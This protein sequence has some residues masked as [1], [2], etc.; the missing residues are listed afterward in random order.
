MAQDTPV[1][2]MALDLAEIKG[3]F[4]DIYATL[5]DWEAGILPQLLRLVESLPDAPSRDKLLHAFETHS[6]VVE[7]ETPTMT[8][9]KVLEETYVRMAAD[10]GVACKQEDKVAFG[11]SIGDWPAFPDTVEAMKILA[12]H[13]KLY[14]LS[15]VDNASFE[16][17]R[18]GP[19]KSGH[20]DGIYTAEM[21]GS[22]KPNPNNYLYVAQRMK[23]DFGMKDSEILP[24]AQSLD[25]DHVTTKTLGFRPGVYITR[26]GSSMGGNK[27]QME[28]DGIIKLGATYA[29]LGELAEAVEK[30]F[31]AKA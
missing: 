23:D 22:Y 10:F 29:T 27:E 2:D 1:A 12:K 31:A 21:I 24:V 9:N 26:S 5:I 8:Y 30:A 16:R 6:D 7:H 15:N 3:L 11:N 28:K 17:T 18:T 25:I 19:L 13:Y 14:V 20:W 4:F